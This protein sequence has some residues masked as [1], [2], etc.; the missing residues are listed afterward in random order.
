MIDFTMVVR[1]YNHRKLYAP[2]DVRRYLYEKS[3]FIGSVGSLPDFE[4]DPGIGKRG[5]SDQRQV[6]R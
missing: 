6:R 2:Q 5:G 4:H 1:Y 3:N